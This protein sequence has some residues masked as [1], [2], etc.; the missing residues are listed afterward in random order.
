MRH[1]K[2]DRMVRFYLCVCVCV[3]TWY[4]GHGMYVCTCVKN[5]VEPGVREARG[6]GQNGT[7]VF[8]CMCVCVCVC[9][10]KV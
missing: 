8:V 1:A 4:E 7:F 9:V 6:N 10:N 2:M 5:A 3:S